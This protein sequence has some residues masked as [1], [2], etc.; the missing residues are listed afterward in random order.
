MNI[1]E[2]INSIIRF[3]ENPSPVNQKRLILG[4]VIIGLFL[5]SWVLFSPYGL[6][7]YYKVK[8]SLAKVRLENQQLKESNQKLRQ[9]MERL[10]SEPEYLEKLVRDNYGYIKKNEMIFE[11]RE[12]KKR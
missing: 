12:K 9:K 7:K 3:L 11:F 1:S 8:D 4:S 10:V 5:L 6:V 2:Q